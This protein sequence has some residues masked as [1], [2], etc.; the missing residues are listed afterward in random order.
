[1]LDYTIPFIKEKYPTSDT[2]VIAANYEETSYMYYL[3]S[4]VVVHVWVI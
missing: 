1:M 2:L 3:K 4:K